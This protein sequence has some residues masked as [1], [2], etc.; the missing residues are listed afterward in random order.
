MC[1]SLNVKDHGTGWSHSPIGDQLETI[2]DYRGKTPP[3]SES[4][5]P[6]ITAANVKSGR[7]DLSTISFVSDETY[8]RWTT[9]GLP[10]SGDVLI[11]TEAPV[12][13]IAPFPGDKTY[14]IT[15][16]VIALRGKKGQLDNRF[17]LY[18]LMSPLAQ[19]YLVSRTRGS[20]V[21]RI[22]K[23]DILGMKIPIPPFQEQRAIAHILGTFDDKIELNRRMN[24]TLE[25]IARAIFKS[26][27]VDFLPVRAKASGEPSDS[28]CRRLGLTPDLLALF[29]GRFQD[30]ELGE[31]PKGWVQK[32]VDDLLK[33]SYGKA[34]KAS[35]RIEGQVP[36]YGSGGI[37]AFHNVHLVDGPGIIV[38]RKGTVDS[39]YWE[40]QPFYPIDT[41]FYVVPKVELTFCFYLLQTLK[42][43]QMNTDAAVP[44]LNRNN[45]YRLPLAWAPG[46][47]RSAFDE[48]VKPLRS[49]KFSNTQ[50]SEILTKIRNTLLPKLLSGELRVSTT[51]KPQ[52]V[53]T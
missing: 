2:I 43:D 18:A 7:I 31:I 10:S 25:A 53:V 12:G 20:T 52:E 28:I 13:E 45:V 46:K 38:G 35:D 14:L 21:P 49:H 1:N 5:I 33:L 8:K 37:T 48:V 22:L 17:L 42:L 19:E 50:Q 51:E 44:G 26:W 24:E 36:V 47:L 11:T 3:K 23:P 16:R 15:R 29:P 6:T 41:V 32:R 9:R 4:G 40:D 39:L 34:L 30:S 27:F